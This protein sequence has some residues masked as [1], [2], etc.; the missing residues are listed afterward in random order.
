[1]VQHWDRE[2]HWRTTTKLGFKHNDDN[3]SGYFNYARGQ[4]SEQLRWRNDGW[5]IAGTARVNYY[6]FPVQT[7]STTD[8]R[9]R[10]QFD[11]TLNLRAERHFGETVKLFVE[12]DR[13]RTLSNVPSDRYAVNT[14]SG[15]LNFEF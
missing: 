7:V 11:L 9:R 12:Y 6:Q 2:R 4:V 5:E 3:G 10:E 15:G 8:P 13:E 1:M 14:V